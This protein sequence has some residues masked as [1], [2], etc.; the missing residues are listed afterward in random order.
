MS[1]R[2]QPFPLTDLQEA[3]VVGSSRLL[4][5]GG[6]QPTYAVELDVVRFEPE[7]AEVATDLLVAR[8]EHLRT[9]VLPGEGQR[10]MERAPSYRIPVEDLRGLGREE[11]EA[12]ID[13]AR[14]LLAAGSDPTCWPL[15]RM[16]A[17]RIRERRTRLHVAMSLLLLDG[18]SIRQVVTEWLRLYADPATRLPPVGPTFRERR[19]WLLDRE[20][21]EAHREDWRYW[22][23]RLDSLPSGPDLPLARPLRDVEPVRFTRRTGRLT[24][25]Q[26]SRLR[27]RVLRQH[28]LAN[29]ALLQ[30]Y[31][32]VLGAWAATPHFC[33]NVLQQ[34][35]GPSVVGQMGSTLAL[36]VDLR[37]GA[38]LCERAERLQ[39]Q[40]WSDSEHGAVSGVRVMREVARRRG[41][42]PRAP[43][44]YV[45]TS[46]SDPVP[47]DDAGAP[48]LAIRIRSSRLATPQV[49]VD[50]QV[51]DESD[52]GVRYTWD[53]VDGAFPP[54]LPDLMFS[55]YRRT[56]EALGA[57]ADR[58]PPSPVPA[59]H[60]EVVA[61]LNDPAWPVPAGRLEDGFL[62]AALAA[63]DARAVVAPDR[64]L[65]YGELERRSRTVA[66]WLRDRDVGGGDVVPVVMARG[67]EQ[68]VA[69]LGVV[70]AGAAYCPID[71]HLPAA[72]IEH[73]LRA[74]AARV[75]LVQ[76]HGGW[77]GDGVEALPVDLA[78]GGE[79]PALP[80]PAG[81]RSTLA[82]V[83]HTSGST[84]TP[85]GVMIDH[86]AA[87]NTVL[88]VN[89]RV[90]IGPA[91]RVFGISSL[92]FDLSVWDVFGTLAA[93]AALVLPAPSD[94]P[95]PEAWA[96][97]AAAHGVT[98]W[99][100]VPALAE[101]LVETREN[102]PELGATPF[103]AFLLSGD[104]IPLSL[105]GRM[106]ALWPDVRVVAMGGATEAS[107]WSNVFEVGDV[108]EAWRSIPYGRP[109]RNQTMR[110]L[111]HRLE[112]R[113][114]WAVG[115][116]HIG[117]AGLARGYL[118][119]EERT[120]ERFVR[121]PATGERLYWTGD[122]GRYWPDGTIELLGR[123]D[124]Q[125]KVQGFRVEPGEV[126]AVLGSHPDVAECVVTAERVPAGQRRLVAIAV[127]RGGS[128]PN[129]EELV[130]HLRARLPHYLVPARL[131][132]V[133]ALPLTANGKVDAARA[134]EELGTPAGTAPEDR[135]ESALERS[136]ATIWHDLLDLGA[137]GP[138]DSFFA[139]GGTSLL[140]L[141]LVNRIRSELGVALPFGQ[142][143]EAPTLRRLAE[144]IAA[145]TG[146][147]GCAVDL[148]VRPGR[149]L[150]LF[151][152]V[153]GSVSAYAALAE[154]WPG[155]VRAMQ[156]AALAGGG[157]A[158]A[159][160]PSMAAGYREELLR[161]QPE[162]PHLLGG[163]SMGGVL[164]QEVGRQLLRMGHRPLVFMI[165]SEVPW[166]P[167]PEA[168]AVASSHLAFLRDLAG[169]ELP[170]GMAAA[171]SRA[172]DAGEAT[173]RAARDACVAAGL[174]P[175]DIGVDGYLDLQRAHAHNS[176]ILSAHAPG[177]WDGPTLLLVAGREEGRPDPATGWSRLCSR[178]EV[179]VWPHDHH[180]IVGA[181]AS[182]AI[183]ERVATWS[184]AE[185]TSS[186]Q[187]TSSE[188]TRA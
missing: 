170:P 164:A 120:A 18:S 113:P 75:A 151:H 9:V 165:D 41:W 37:D 140:T 157:A 111:D 105:P 98:L 91:D 128:A 2:H 103:R 121:H 136:L 8:H 185:A 102:R 82:Y 81:E 186:E 53:V 184:R 178:L 106:R 139:L 96:V 160:V 153:G 117:G 182:V 26:W 84:G 155:P 138:D 168:G 145:G 124:D 35:P 171:V 93:G 187:A 85:K 88:D 95:D 40:L 154:A 74:S 16:L 100:S 101:M 172:G 58:T 176:A 146:S 29:S 83:I 116:I 118:G 110:V 10:A 51:Q 55:A 59:L 5:L 127:P 109:L 159:D 122:L 25:A 141:R 7:R 15:F 17:Q 12:A 149:P 134:L 132:L 177:G 135:P 50:L 27:S 66:R 143:F 69:V 11:R 107:V 87:L 36:E 32:D 61:A 175:A 92:S 21:S 77:A 56:L 161:R 97:A 99:N 78:A 57:E 119:D 23:A 130:A 49:L 163:W 123:E 162:G 76:S 158:A 63:P 104:W 6:V 180:S 133:P 167:A 188:E 62:A 142:V 94:M 108:D 13:R 71:A 129:R 90:R 28:V 3:Y 152:P 47:G 115:R 72:R 174:L 24:P 169:G 68:V 70:R 34:T 14:E 64:T 19:V 48:A 114:P 65:T 181:L 46:M 148:A 131:E 125:V 183:A 126:E 89:E 1:E 79:T 31:A 150:W 60:R 22:E 30:A 112:V 156:S 45:F 73:L 20:R 44:P 67:W 54:G 39:R 52:G 147:D 33:L 42:P 86:R 166:E 43:L 137:V 179:E 173:D 144:R 80:G 4:E 38:T